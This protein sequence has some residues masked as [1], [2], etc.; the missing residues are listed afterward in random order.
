[1]TTRTPSITDPHTGGITWQARQPG[2][3]LWIA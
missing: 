1:M 2:L 3:H